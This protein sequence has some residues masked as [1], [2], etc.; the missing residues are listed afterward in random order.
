MFLAVVFGRS[1]HVRVV[2]EDRFFCLHCKADRGYQLRDWRSARTLFFIPL[3]SYGGKFVL[4]STCKTAFDPECLDESST[5]ELHELEV[6]P[7]GFAC[8]AVLTLAGNPL[9]DHQGYVR[10]DRGASAPEVDRSMPVGPGAQGRD[11]PMSAYS[12]F[13]KH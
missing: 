12:A 6:D 10:N 4:C 1:H 11:K 9:S 7:P 2:G 5:A 13:R 3:G 8:A